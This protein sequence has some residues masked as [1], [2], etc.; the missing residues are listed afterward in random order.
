MF[1][2]RCRGTLN[3][4]AWNQLTPDEWTHTELSSISVFDDFVTQGVY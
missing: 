1:L 3:L 4:I 2:P